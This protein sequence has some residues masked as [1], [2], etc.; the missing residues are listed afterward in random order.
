MR[1]ARNKKD[2]KHFFM[3]GLL[4]CIISILSKNKG[5]APAVY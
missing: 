3:Y 2:L 4:T 1:V 5:L